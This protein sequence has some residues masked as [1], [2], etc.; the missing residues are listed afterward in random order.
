MP[1]TK[2]QVTDDPI[3][4]HL[5]CYQLI[6]VRW[7]RQDQALSESEL[8]NIHNENAR[9]MEVLVGGEDIRDIEASMDKDSL[10]EM[11]KLDAKLNLL[12]GW[13]GQLLQQQLHLPPAQTVCLS[14]CGLQFQSDDSN[15]GAL[16]EDDN[17]CI[18]MFLDPSYPQAFTA[19][20][21]VVK[22]NPQAPSPGVEIVARF[23]QLSEQN[24]IWL[25]KYV[26]QLHRRQVALSRKHPQ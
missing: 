5:V 8:F 17:L 9:L 6:P 24:Q 16:R 23:T 3:K 21:E 13:I 11:K 19:V 20:S 1:E 2:S 7:R 18:E 15:A 12:M 14:A 10:K 4:D 22:V 26:F 25:D